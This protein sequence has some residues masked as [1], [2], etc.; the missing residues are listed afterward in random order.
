MDL[1]S[2]RDLLQL[3]LLAGDMAEQELGKDFPD[4]GKDARKLERLAL[5]LINQALDIYKRHSSES[6]K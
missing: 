5:N 3:W 2:I 1:E 6:V 4:C